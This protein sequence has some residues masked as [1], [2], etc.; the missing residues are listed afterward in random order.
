[1]SLEPK[2]IHYCWFGRGHLPEHAQRTLMSWQKFAPGFEI[3]C[4][5]E[6]V[7]N[8]SSCEWTKKAYEAKKYAFVAD[9][10]RFRMLYDMGGIYMDLGSELVRDITELVETTSP[11]SAIEELSKTANTGLIVA[12]PPHNPV[13]AT[14]LSRYESTEFIDD[15][16]FLRNHTVNEFFTAELEKMGFVRENRLQN[17]GGWTLLPSVT[18]N[19]V[20]GF[21]GYHVKAETYSIHHY[22]A[23]WEDMR[24]QVKGEFVRKFAPYIG[25]RPAQILGRIKGELVMRLAKERNDTEVTRLGEK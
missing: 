22:S 18:F 2:V 16:Q 13:I 8:V 6:T 23:S 9:Y 12:T 14:V 10:A 5:D 4:C 15:V 25:R 17:V 7:F 1:M 24:F 3:R 11:F 20:Y 21:G 19:P